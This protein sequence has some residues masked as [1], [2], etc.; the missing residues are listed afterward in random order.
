MDTSLQRFED[1]DEKYERYS[2]IRTGASMG[3]PLEIPLDLTIRQTGRTVQRE[4]RI[5][6]GVN[7]T[8]IGTRYL[9]LLSDITDI[10]SLLADRTRESCGR[11]HKGERR[12]STRRDL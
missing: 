3:K 7:Y 8:R 10:S 1:Q 12:R 5:E 11:L 6:H 9:D 4:S 2:V